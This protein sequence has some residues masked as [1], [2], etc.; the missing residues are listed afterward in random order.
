MLVFF[1]HHHTSSIGTTKPIIPSTMFMMSQPCAAYNTSCSSSGRWFLWELCT[2]IICHKLS[3]S[4]FHWYCSTTKIKVIVFHLFEL[5]HDPFKF[6][7]KH[8]YCIA[9]NFRYNLI[10]GKFGNVFTYFRIIPKFEDVKCAHM[11]GACI[12]CISNTAY[13]YPTSTSSWCIVYWN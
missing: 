1:T 8:H 5:P 12:F 2:S 6:W 9:G 13:M 11:H 7:K 3:L 10:F 4:L